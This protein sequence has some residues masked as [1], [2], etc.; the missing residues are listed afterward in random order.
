MSLSQVLTIGA[1][2]LGLIALGTM[3]LPRRVNVVRKTRI[4]ASPRE[5]LALA[6]SNQ[7]YQ[8]FNPYKNSDDAL[9]IETFGP[10]SGV[11]SG[12][13]FEGKDGKGSQTVAAVATDR[14]DYA[15]DLGPMGKPQQ[16]IKATPC[17]E[18]SEVVWTM[19]ADLG[20]NPIA[21]IFGL[22]MD[23]MVGKVFETGFANLALATQSR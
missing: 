5:I 3:L 19:Q 9:K 20:M 2:A 14:V 12:F 22:F 6:A 1:S 17:E 10:S 8:S 23:R 15:I 16:S 4:K 11:G 21:R 7:G 13:H 18:G